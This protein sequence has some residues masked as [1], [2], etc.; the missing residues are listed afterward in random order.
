V[1]Q[2]AGYLS[3]CENRPATGTNPHHQA[4][5]DGHPHVVVREKARHGPETAPR[6]AG[7]VKR[8]VAGVIASRRATIRAHHPSNQV[9]VR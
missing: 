5:A 6:P 2:T 8:D 3:W 1:T 9:C 4:V 7:R